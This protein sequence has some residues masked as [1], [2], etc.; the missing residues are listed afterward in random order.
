M[1]ML[2]A[3]ASSAFCS[4]FCL[5]WYGLPR[6]REMGISTWAVPLGPV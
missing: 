2:A 6:M 1:A 3:S 4:T 5:G